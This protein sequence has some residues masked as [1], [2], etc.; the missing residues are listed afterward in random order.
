[1]FKDAAAATAA[2]AASNSGSQSAS[3]PAAGRPK[4][5][6]KQPSVRPK[7]AQIRSDQ[8]TGLDETARMLMDARTRIGG[9]RITANTLIRVAIDALLATR[10]SLVGNEEDE[11]RRRYFETLGI[12]NIPKSGQ[13]DS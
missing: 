3:Q 5:A 12:R 1:M 10:G 2:A 7:Y 6:E 13:Q 8:W 11:L 4:A 9:P